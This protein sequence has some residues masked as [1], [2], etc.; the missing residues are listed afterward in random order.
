MA[1]LRL[2]ADAKADLRDIAN[3][4]AERWSEAAAFTFLTEIYE[5]FELL[6][7]HPDIGR[8]RD[9]V[10][11]GSRA[12]LLRGYLIYY[13]HAGNE[14]AVGRIMHGSADPSQ[15]PIFEAL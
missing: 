3:Y 6:E 4:G 14:V 5:A 1:K 13:V 11:P 15:K 10:W 12:W 8:P 9:D 2:S 7:R